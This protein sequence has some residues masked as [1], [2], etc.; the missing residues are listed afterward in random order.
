MDDSNG[1]VQGYLEDKGLVSSTF[2]CIERVKSS[3]NKRTK[4]N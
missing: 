4:T 1:L 2:D 3:I